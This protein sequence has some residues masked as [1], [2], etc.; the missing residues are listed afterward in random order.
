MNR[1]PTPEDSVYLG[2]RLD[3]HRHE[4]QRRE[5]KVDLL[6]S[7]GYGV[8]FGLALAAEVSIWLGWRP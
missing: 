5:R 4:Q 8:L 2:D 3:R 6:T 1:V 7:F